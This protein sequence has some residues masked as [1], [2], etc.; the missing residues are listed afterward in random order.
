M[1]GR[2]QCALA[3]YRREGEDGQVEETVQPLVEELGGGEVEL[4][5]PV[6][7]E[8]DKPPGG[9]IVHWEPPASFPTGEHAPKSCLRMRW[10]PPP[11]FGLD[12]EAIVAAAG[13]DKTERACERARSGLRDQRG[14]VLGKGTG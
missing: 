9:I 5:P 8:R 10:R 2:N 3:Q 1:P 7:V 11:L 6:T 4:L 12:V 14:I 13:D